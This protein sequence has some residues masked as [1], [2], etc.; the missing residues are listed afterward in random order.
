MCALGEAESLVAF[1]IIIKTTRVNKSFHDSAA[2]HAE[3]AAAE[4]K[5]F[6]ECAEVDYC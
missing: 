5:S 3:D 2:Y 1:T 4:K 6:A